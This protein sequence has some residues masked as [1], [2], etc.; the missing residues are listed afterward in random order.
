MFCP[1][2]GLKNPD[3]VLR[4][5]NCGGEMPV[6]G[7]NQ[8]SWFAYRPGPGVGCMIGLA[9]IGLLSLVIVI[10]QYLLY[11]RNITMAKEAVVRTNMRSLRVALDQCAAEYGLYPVGLDAR[12][13]RPGEPDL[14]DVRMMLS[15]LQN[16]FDPILPA[17]TVSPADPP[18][19]KTV[20]PG[21]VVY[22]PRDTANGWARS[23][24]IFGMGKQ[25]LLP[26]TLRGGF[27]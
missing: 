19:W 24:L 13:N 4:C 18:D 20:K 25:R 21:Q 8:K 11:Q 1:F 2:C 9:M 7:R 26:D 3:G 27:Q 23:Y 15:R 10:P 6:P 5:T 22:V 14:R 17:V 16:P 12:D